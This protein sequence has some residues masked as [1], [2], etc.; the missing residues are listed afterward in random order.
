MMKQVFALCLINL[1]LSLSVYSEKFEP[2]FYAFLNGMPPG[3]APEKEAEMLKKLGYA[4]VS[5][6][7]GLNQHI[8]TRSNIYRKHG[9]KVLSVY[10]NAGESPFPTEHLKPLANQGFMIELTLQKKSP[11]II[12][13][14]RQTCD[15]MAA[16]GIKVTLYPHAG[17]AVATIPQAMEVIKE[18]NHPNLG[19]TFNLCHF[20]KSEKAEDLEKTLDTCAPHLFSVTTNG[21]DID[22]KHWPTLIQTLDKGSFPQ[23]RLFKKLKELNF[24]GPVGLQGFGIKGDKTENISKSIK[25]WQ[26]ILKEVNASN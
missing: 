15:N 9:L 21:A 5:Q 16:L 18:V 14:I 1:V 2:Q 19:I 4:G 22:G 23:E 24:K 11:K 13:A 3:T 17:F 25:A 20:L 8:A 6:V 7:F 10:L 26:D 12:A